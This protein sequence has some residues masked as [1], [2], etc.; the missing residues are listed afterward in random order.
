MKNTN[1]KIYKISRIILSIIAYILFSIITINEDSSWI[2][3]PII[4]A[5]IVFGLSFPSTIFANKIISI[6]DNIKGKTLKFLYYLIL[7]FVLLAICLALYS[8]I[9]YI[10]DTYYTVSNE[11][12]PALGHGLFVLFL[13]IVGAIC[14]IIPYIQALI[15]LLLRKFIKD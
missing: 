14:I 12:G 1:K 8:F 10:D 15:V 5:V 11:L 9:I 3:V 7:P 13:T 4:F 6:G 2:I